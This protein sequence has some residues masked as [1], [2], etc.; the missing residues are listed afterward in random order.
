V[1]SN[2]TC[3]YLQTGKQLR[4]TVKNEGVFSMREIMK[5]DYD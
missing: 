2:N 3:V 1:L 5:Y 4:N